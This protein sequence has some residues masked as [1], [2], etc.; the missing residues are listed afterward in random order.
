MKIDKIDLK[1]I[2]NMLYLEGKEVTSTQLTKKL[3]NISDRKDLQNK[4][5][6]LRKRLMKLTKYGILEKIN[7]NNKN[8]YIIKPN[9]IF[10]GFKGKEENIIF[11]IDVKP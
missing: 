10:I 3:F 7:N 1:I 8:Y 2:I 9:A 11:W 6:N 4:D 5:A